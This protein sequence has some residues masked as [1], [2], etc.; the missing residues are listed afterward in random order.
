MKMVMMIIDQSKREELEIFLDRS[1][2]AGYTELSG[3][4][5]KGESGLRLGSRAFPR[6]SSV[7][8]SLLE[9]MEVERLTAGLDEFCSSCGEQLHMFAWEVEQI[10]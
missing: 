6:T 1:G 3:A 5:G 9:N 8:F 10:R 2:V 4:A 7:V